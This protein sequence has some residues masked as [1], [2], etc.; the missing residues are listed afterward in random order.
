MDRKKF[1]M[2]PYRRGQIVFKFGLLVFLTVPLSVMYYKK[3][4]KDIF[5]AGMI[6]DMERISK[7]GRSYHEIPKY[8]VSEE[9]RN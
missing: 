8:E 7:S 3:H 2:K 6:A 4:Q 5:A 9:K 1:D